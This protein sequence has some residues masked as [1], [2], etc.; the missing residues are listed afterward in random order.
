MKYFS[1]RGLHEMHK[2]SCPG[3]DVCYLRHQ[4]INGHWDSMKFKIDNLL[5]VSSHVGSGGT[6]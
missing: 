6:F 1:W 4:M 2:V 3:N 5:E